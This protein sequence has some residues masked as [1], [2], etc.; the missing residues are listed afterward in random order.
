MNT[1]F[2]YGLL[3]AIVNGLICISIPVLV[4]YTQRKLKPSQDALEPIVLNH[5]ELLSS[6]SN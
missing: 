4:S 6:E 3:L 5:V 2:T 1:T